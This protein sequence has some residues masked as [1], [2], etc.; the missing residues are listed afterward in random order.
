MNIVEWIKNLFKKNVVLS[1]HQK[2][3][4]EQAK[5]NSILSSF[6]EMSEQ[7][8][9]VSETY[10]TI[11]QEENDDIA[12]IKEY[13]E[14]QIKEATERIELAS[15]KLTANKKLHEKISEFLPE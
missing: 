10:N 15:G 3:E 6:I 1:N 7:L 12:R 4:Q 13:A 5:V 2:M 14:K 11:I 9:S 8:H